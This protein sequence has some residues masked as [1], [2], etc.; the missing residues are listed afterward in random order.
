MARGEACPLKVAGTGGNIIIQ[1]LRFDGH[2]GFVGEDGA[3]HPP[4]W[5]LREMMVRGMHNLL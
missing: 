5:Q 1:F 3:F 2:A 4:H